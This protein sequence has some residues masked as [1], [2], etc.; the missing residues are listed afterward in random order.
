MRRV[1]RGLLHGGDD[2]KDA[3][4]VS[5]MELLSSAANYEGRGP[6]E[7]WAQR[8]STRATL[9]WMNKQKR[10][11]ERVLAQTRELDVRDQQTLLQT[12]TLER[13]PRPLEEYLEQLTE[14]QRV[15]VLLRYALGHTLPEIAGIT[16]APVPTVKSRI[17]KGYQELCRLVRRDLNLGVRQ[18]D[19]DS[20][21]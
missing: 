17:N 14:V 7:A 12:E 8:I 19:S 21:D 3:A 16:D 10:Q 11:R 18:S 6:L 5:L 2:A 9:R 1:S 20:Q 13:L 15:A 4:Q